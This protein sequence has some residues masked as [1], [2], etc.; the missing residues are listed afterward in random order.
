MKRRHIILGFIVVNLFLV[1]GVIY[2]SELISISVSTL[3]ELRVRT[4]LVFVVT[5]QV[6]PNESAT[7]TSGTARFHWSQ[8]ETNDY[9][10][11]VENLGEIGC[12]RA[13]IRDIV[14]AR[15]MDDYADRIWEVQKPMQDRFWEFV[16]GGV[17]W[18][19]YPVGD[20]V[21]SEVN[22]LEKTRRETLAALEKI[23][24]EPPKPFEMPNAPA[25]SFLPEDKRRTVIAAYATAEAE[26][27]RFEKALKAE[28]ADEKAIRAEVKRSVELRDL[29]VRS[30][31]TPEEWTQVQ[32]RLNPSARWAHNLP[33]VA[34]SAEENQAVALAKIET[35]RELPL[36]PQ[37]DPKRSDVEKMRA[38]AT[39]QK[40][41]EILGADKMREV[42]R[43]GDGT[44]Q[45]L[46]KII[47]R[48]SKP[49]EVAN[50][51]Y[52]VKRI[53]EQQVRSIVSNPIYSA[54]SKAAAYRALREETERE[55]RRVIGV[56]VWPTFVRYG[57]DWWKQ[58]GVV[59][60]GR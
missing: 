44:Y 30:T 34:L 5:N 18:N 38:D 15:V 27:A 28:D 14:L 59:E 45:Q 23:L 36:P 60:G 57:G 3:P 47:R 56:E 8:L 40:M 51:A 1:A 35:N 39:R 29:K 12:P 20:A 7:E 31:L 43:A 26:R 2:Q 54:E 41:A 17:R 52:E 21:E 4:N 6:K 24:A 10:R 49:M 25:W 13:T 9:A 22:A 37:K 16:A 11:L 48:H 19:D 55:L 46:R 32:A 50:Q 58:P 42:E 33:G 53:V